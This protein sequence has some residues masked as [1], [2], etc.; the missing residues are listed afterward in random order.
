VSGNMIEAQ[1]SAGALGTVFYDDFSYLR[2][3]LWKATST[4]AGPQGTTLLT[5]N[6]KFTGD[7]LVVSSDTVTHTGGEYQTVNTYSYGN[8][9]TSMR[10][11]LT[12]GTFATLMTYSSNAGVRDEIDIQF[13]KADGKNYVYF[14]TAA[15]GGQ[16]L[17]K[18][19]L[20][21]DPAASYHTYGFN[22]QAG[23]VDFSVDGKIVWTSAKNIPSHSSRLIFNNWVTKSPPSGSTASKLYAAYVS[24]DSQGSVTPTPTPTATPKP[25]STPTPTPTLKPTATPT[26]TPK[27]TATP[28]PTPKPTATPTATPKPVT[29]TPSPSIGL[30]LRDDFNSLNSNVWTVSAYDQ[31]SFIDTTFLKENVWFSDGKLVMKADVNKHTGGELKSK[32]LFTYGKYRASMKLDATPGSFLTFF[33]Y[34]WAGGNGGEK[35]NEV[36]IEVINDGKTA[37]LTT[38]YDGKRN[39]KAYTLP[40][41]AAAAYHVYG[42]DWYK[43]HVDFFIDGKLIWT[44]TSII[45]NQPTYLYFN[46]WVIKD[47]PASHGNGINTQYVDWVTVEKI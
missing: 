31:N 16:N 1:D 6:I 44:S 5:S 14:A 13:Q 26:A 32:Q 22:W 40:F 41:D 21:F 35:H 47:V 42:Y 8:Y 4:T 39:Y 7:C 17:Y 3:D 24:I 29:P 36:D 11:D 9:K 19:E 10:L 12:P 38:W 45:P 46:S 25:T 15:N 23:Q 43:D 28:T 34:I 2:S 27:P 33:N 18:Y 20:P 30:L 37:L